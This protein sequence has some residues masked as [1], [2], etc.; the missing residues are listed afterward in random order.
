VFLD[1]FDQ[2]G[3]FFMVLAG[4]I[5]LVVVLYLIVSRPKKNNNNKIMSSIPKEEPIQKTN[6][7]V[8]K[9]ELQGNQ[10]DNSL[11]V[12]EEK[13]NLFKDL[14]KEEKQEPISDE[15]IDLVKL[16]EYINE[17]HADALPVFFDEVKPKKE[18][19]EEE[20]EET[21]LDYDD[22]EEEELDEHGKKKVLGR[23][24]VLYK[25]DTNKWYIKREGSE[26]VVKTLLTQKEAVAYAT[27][28]AINQ[29]TTVVVH[30]KDGKIRKST[31]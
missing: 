14:P 25:K 20:E 1:L 22:D 2:Y 11:K 19:P 30:K 3:T 31:L 12:L 18:E 27:I 26:K 9:D 5:I 29:K 21:V 13:K 4:V 10:S 8:T 6:N 15:I 28:K 7:Q 24:H 16:D 23:Y 17:H